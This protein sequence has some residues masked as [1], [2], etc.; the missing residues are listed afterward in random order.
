MQNP[1]MVIES[2][3][4][5]NYSKYNSYIKKHGRDIYGSVLIPLSDV[6]EILNIAIEEG[7]SNSDIYKEFIERVIIDLTD[8]LFLVQESSRVF[9]VE[10]VDTVFSLMIQDLNVIGDKY[11]DFVR[12]FGKVKA[13]IENRDGNFTLLHADKLKEQY[14]NTVRPLLLYKTE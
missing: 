6:T 3:Y 8:H 2:A 4:F 12:S 9:G 7:S 5:E 10:A 14:L 11:N 13:M 1:L